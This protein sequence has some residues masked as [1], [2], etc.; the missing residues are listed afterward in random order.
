MFELRASHLVG[1]LSTTQAKPP[2]LFALV[3]FHTGSSI[4]AKGGAGPWSSYLSFPRSWDDKY[5]TL[6]PPFLL[7]WSLTNFLPRLVLNC[8]PSYLCLPKSRVPPWT[9]TPSQQ[10][11]IFTDTKCYKS[12]GFIY[13]FI[14]WTSMRIHGENH[15]S[16]LP[17]RISRI[18]TTSEEEEV[19]VKSSRQ[20]WWVDMFRSR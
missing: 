12:L 14:T 8:N 20:G 19:M 1:K 3:I 17:W 5:L 13:M 6:C 18:L 10:H 11:A 4:F 15:W 16:V 9:T 2:A 7:Q